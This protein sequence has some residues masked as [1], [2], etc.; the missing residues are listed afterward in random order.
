MVS[1]G[2]LGAGRIGQIHA[3]N[4]DRQE[5]AT[6]KYVVDSNEASA[7]DIAARFGAEVTEAQSLFDD[8]ELDA[9]VIATPTDTHA[10]LIAAAAESGKAIFCEKPID[11]SLDKVRT[12]LDVVERT[13]ALLAIGFNR[14]F[15][16]SIAALKASIERGDIGEVETVTIVSRDPAPPPLEY[17]RVSGGIFRDMMIHDFDIARW[18]LGEEPVSVFASGSC[19]IDQGIG[20]AGDFDTAI[21]VL[22]T[23]SGKLCHIS[24]N[25]RCAFGYDQRIEVFGSEGSVATGNKVED[26]VSLRNDQGETTARPLHFFLQR[27]A[28]A[29][30]LEM[31]E[32][33]S[34]VDESREFPVGGYDGLRAQQLAD[35]A[36]ASSQLSVECEIPPT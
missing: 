1:V 27:Y 36:Y 4:V 30:A 11:L 24:N 2:L 31:A 8:P 15:D 12:S 26:T 35:C 34:A 6:L 10:D 17:I 9:V 25:R 14:R 33:I 19:L 16:P 18:L 21:A 23:E 20:E 7:H 13:G 22:R 3:Q 29:Y 28:Q 32:F 5:G